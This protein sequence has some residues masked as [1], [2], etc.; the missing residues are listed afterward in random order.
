MWSK[1]NFSQKSWDADVNA[2]WEGW[3]HPHTEDFWYLYSSQ[4]LKTLNYSWWAF[5]ARLL[6]KRELLSWPWRRRQR[7]RPVK[8]FCTAQHFSSQGELLWSPFVR[9]SSS[10]FC[11]QSLWKFIRTY[12]SINSR[13]SS[14]LGHV[15]SKT[16]SL[17]QIYEKS[18]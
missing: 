9:R 10:T 8:V 12:I 14:K 6:K 2:F 17:G 11:I 18:C 13:P 16:R 3:T 15:R 5:L 4:L 7:G 1:S